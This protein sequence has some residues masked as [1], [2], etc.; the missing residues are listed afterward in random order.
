MI[1]DINIHDEK[2]K[3]QIYY[4]NNI[5]KENNIDNI[6][7]DLSYNFQKSSDIIEKMEAPT[8]TLIALIIGSA[9]INKINKNESK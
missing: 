7:K 9:L 5:F 4:I 1:N 8:V 2:L 3:T 6:L